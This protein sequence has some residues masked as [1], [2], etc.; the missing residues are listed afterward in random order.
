MQILEKKGNCPRE[1]V[2]RYIKT[3]F[4]ITLLTFLNQVIVDHLPAVYRIL[5]P[6]LPISLSS[7]SHRSVGPESIISLI[8]NI[9]GKSAGLYRPLDHPT[10]F[11]S[12]TLDLNL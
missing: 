5:E 9:N 1:A 8:R 3:T 6:F 7:K 12:R 4:F 10:D 2:L 11:P